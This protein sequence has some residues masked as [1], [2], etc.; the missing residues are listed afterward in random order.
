MFLYSTRVPVDVWIARCICYQRHVCMFTYHIGWCRTWVQY[1]EPNMHTTAQP[2]GRRTTVEPHIRQP[3]WTIAW[4]F[5]RMSKNGS[6]MDTVPRVTISPEKANHLSRNVSTIIFVNHLIDWVNRTIVIWLWSKY[7]P[8]DKKSC[9]V[10]CWAT[11][12]LLCKVNEICSAD[13]H[14]NH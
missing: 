14:E 6:H 10:F 7:L 12:P 3:S 9:F 2:T 4:L 1:T 5:Q 13:Y 11:L 8:E